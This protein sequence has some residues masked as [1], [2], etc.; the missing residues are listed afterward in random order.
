MRLLA[1]LMLVLQACPGPR[2]GV[3]LFALLTWVLLAH[4]QSL[5]PSVQLVWEGVSHPQLAGYALQRCTVPPGQSTCTTVDLPG[6]TTGIQVTT[7]TDT[8]VVSGVTYLYTV[9][10]L[11]PACTP[12]RSAASNLVM[13]VVGA[14][15]ASPPILSASVFLPQAGMTAAASSQDPGMEARRAIDGQTGTFWHTRWSTAPVPSY[16]HWLRLDLRT[17]WWVSGLI[18]LPRQD[19]S[20]G[21]IKTYRIEGSQDGITWSVLATGSFTP[22]DARPKQVRWASVLVRWLKVVALSSVN[23]AVFA[24]AADITLLQGQATP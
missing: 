10:A 19:M 21:W 1:W 11:C 8:Q 13:V 24:G 9:V 14:P 7:Y 3:T 6:A 4:A 5:S 23:G 16:P 22:D 2:A 20:N 12:T 18:Y 17:A 15:P